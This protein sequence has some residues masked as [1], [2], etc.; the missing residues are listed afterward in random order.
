MLTVRHRSGLPTAS[1]CLHAKAGCIER[2]YD[3]WSDGACYLRELEKCI[4]SVI[5]WLTPATVT[6]LI[7]REAIVSRNANR[8]IQIY[9]SRRLS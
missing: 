1:K 9:S 3:R 6:F 2:M 7:E 5:D 8:K 4:D